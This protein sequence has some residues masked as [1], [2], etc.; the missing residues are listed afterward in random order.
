MVGKMGAMNLDGM[1]T[2]AMK[3]NPQAMMQKL[4]GALD[5]GIVKQMG[6]MG[7]LMNMVQQF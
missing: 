7:N 6:G 3:K 5:P 4:Q 1:D 2:D